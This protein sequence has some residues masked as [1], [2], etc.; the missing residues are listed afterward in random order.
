MSRS[1]VAQRCH[2]M[3]RPSRSRVVGDRVAEVGD[4]EALR[5]AH[6]EARVVGTGRQ[7]LLPGLV[8]RSCRPSIPS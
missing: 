2:W 6:P 1:S 4:W 8:E 3:I 5:R 7:L